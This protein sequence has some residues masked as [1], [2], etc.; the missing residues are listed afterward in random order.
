MKNLTKRTVTLAAQ[1]RAFGK[2]VDLAEKTG[3]QRQN[4]LRVL[5]YHR[6]DWP[7][8]RPEL[9][10]GLISATPKTF[11]LQMQ[12]LASNYHVI[13]MTELLDMERTGR[14]L[15]PRCL[16]L[17][18]DDAY[19]DFAEYAW[20]ILQRYRLP[21][22][23]FVPTAFPDQPERTFW[24]DRLYQSVISTTRRDDLHTS[25]GNLG[26]DT[27][28]ERV[29]TFRQLKVQVKSMPHHEAMDWIE[30]L[31]HELGAAPSVSNVLGWETLRRLASA[32]V[33]LGAHTQTHPMVNRISRE[34]IQDEVAGS[35]SDLERETGSA[36]PVF[37]YPSGGHDQEAVQ[38]LREEGIVLAFTTERG[39]NDLG[40]AE[41]LRLRR[42]NVGARTTL[43][44]LRAQLLPWSVGF[45][46][47]RA[48]L[49][50]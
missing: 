6:V 49:G 8:T 17:T 19:A 29:Q 7:D 44:I 4:L 37:A 5:T 48:S 31:S 20:P 12:Y 38:V 33:T 30:Q 50:R 16:L 14:A 45:G 25:L 13:S 2:M 23:L 9:D 22:T 47:W 35:L 11:D 21:V 43:A 28:T 15:P 3:D 32:G 27:A 26:L 18:F 42:F 24:W 10:P 1:S 46:Q 34:E 39:A 36:L 40:N 41:R